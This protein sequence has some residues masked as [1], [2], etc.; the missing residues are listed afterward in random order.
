MSDNDEDAFAFTAQGDAEGNLVLTAGLSLKESR[1]RSEEERERTEARFRSAPFPLFGLPP[2]WNGA[3][4]LGGGWWGGMP[5]EERTKALSLVHGTLV[6]GEGPILGVE[7]AS[8]FSIG[9][10][11]LLN[12]AGMVWEGISPSIEEAFQELTR[13]DP[14][15]DLPDSFPVRSE[16]VFTVDAV[17]TSFDAFVDNDE[18]VARAEVGPLYVT[19]TG[20]FFYTAEVALVRIID[21]EPYV[22][23][24]RQFYERG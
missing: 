11:G 7:T 20:N 4:F 8:G 22:L 15:W 10:G 21:I 1:R 5:G 9:G 18:W 24:T 6:Q 16:L 23:G 2:S 14:H 13:D 3:R 17:P 12:S 19:V